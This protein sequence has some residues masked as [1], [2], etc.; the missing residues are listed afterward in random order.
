MNVDDNPDMTLVSTTISM[1]TTL[2]C[3]TKLEVPVSASLATLQQCVTA[4]H[5]WFSQ[6]GLLLNP[7]KSEV[8]H[9]HRDQT[10]SAHLR[11]SMQRLSPLLVAQ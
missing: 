6:N 8:I 2:S 1:L 5:A 7:D 10:T 3:N 4:L 11:A 9:V